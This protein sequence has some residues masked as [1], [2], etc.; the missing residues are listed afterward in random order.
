[1][2]GTRCIILTFL[3]ADFC[4]RFVLYPDVESNERE[5]TT[6]NDVLL[7]KLLQNNP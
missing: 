2:Y 5:N 1:M 7:V 3:T 6:W 4:S